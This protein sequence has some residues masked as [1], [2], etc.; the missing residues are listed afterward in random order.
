[1]NVK[2]FSDKI[3][4]LKID[5]QISY[6]ESICLFCENTGMEVELASKLIS[7]KIK[8]YVEAEASDL[9]MLKYKVNIKTLPI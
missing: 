9:N 7:P 3:E 6:F 5:K 8:E 4:A 2:D 1:M